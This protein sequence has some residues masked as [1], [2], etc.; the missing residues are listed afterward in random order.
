MQR[1]ICV[2]RKVKDK[3]EEPYLWDENNN[4]ESSYN[5]AAENSIKSNDS[6]EEDNSKVI[7]KVTCQNDI[8]LYALEQAKVL[9]EL[10]NAQVKSMKEN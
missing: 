5:S 3:K 8:L 7:A 6:V 4:K 2:G 9:E 1:K 10:F